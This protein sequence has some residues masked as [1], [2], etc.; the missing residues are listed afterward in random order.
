MAKRIEMSEQ[1]IMDNLPT[2]PDNFSYRVEQ[3]SKLV[4]RVWIINHGTFTYKEDGEEIKSI[5][6]FIKSTGEVVKPRN[7]EKI[8][9]E[10]LCKVTEIPSH[11]RY[12]VMQPRYTTLHSLFD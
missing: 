10:K 4:W 11:W 6:G 12:S 3:F 7:S 2:P 9:T 1:V 5:W 8:S